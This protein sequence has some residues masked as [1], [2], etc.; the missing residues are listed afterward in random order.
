VVGGGDAELA[1]HVRQPAGGQVEVGPR[2][3]GVGFEP[4]EQDP[5]RKGFGWAE[6]GAAIHQQPDAEGDAVLALVGVG[7]R[8]DGGAG[9]V[10]PVAAGEV[11]DRDQGFPRVGGPVLHGHGRDGAGQGLDVVTDPAGEL[12]AELVEGWTVAAGP[13]GL[14]AF[15]WGA[16]AHADDDGPVFDGVGHG[17]PMP[18]SATMAKVEIR[19]TFRVEA[20]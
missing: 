4:V 11:G 10:G 18:A 16:A 7:E 15:V 13:V 19:S 8:D 5:G 20:S 9:G 3:F 1:R 14:D 12:V 17:A 6:D 2:G